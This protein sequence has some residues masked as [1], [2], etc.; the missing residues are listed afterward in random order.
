MDDAARINQFLSRRSEARAEAE[1]QMSFGLS[2]LNQAAAFGPMSQQSSS[3]SSFVNND[4]ASNPSFA[5]LANALAF[6]SQ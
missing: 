6:N 1:P 3:S 4:L 5:A 2:A